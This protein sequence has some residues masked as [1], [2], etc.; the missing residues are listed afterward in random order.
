MSVR[1]NYRMFLS[2]L[3][4]GVRED[5]QHLCWDVLPGTPKVV[6]LRLYAQ[7]TEG[8]IEVAQAEIAV[9]GCELWDPG[10][11][12]KAM[13]EGHRVIGIQARMLGGH[14]I[15]QG[16]PEFSLEYLEVVRDLRRVQSYEEILDEWCH[17]HRPNYRMG[18]TLTEEEAPQIRVCEYSHGPRRSDRWEEVRRTEFAIPSDGSMSMLDLVEK[19]ADPV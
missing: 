4:A 9:P 19:L 3:Q 6:W 12:D 13:H 17:N 8:W 5:G 10:V 1:V 16:I 2:D 7:H 14:P 18:W 11:V 15:Y